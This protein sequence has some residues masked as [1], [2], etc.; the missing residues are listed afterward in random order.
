MIAVLFCDWTDNW[1]I[2]GDKFALDKVDS[3]FCSLVFA[4]WGV[5]LTPF[6]ATLTLD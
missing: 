2:G 4:G 1:I 6:D 5:V 3:V